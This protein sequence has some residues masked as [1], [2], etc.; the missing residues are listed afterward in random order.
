[1]AAHLSEEDKSKILQLRFVNGMKEVTIAREVGC[2]RITVIKFVKQF[3][4][5]G[6]LEQESPHGRHTA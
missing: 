5:T 4:A 1:M 3:E 2:S 6:H